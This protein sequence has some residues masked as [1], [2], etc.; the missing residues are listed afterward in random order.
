MTR[1]IDRAHP[2]TTATELVAAVRALD[3]LRWVEASRAELK[4]NH[5]H[6]VV[7]LTNGV[8]FTHYGCDLVES[9]RRTQLQLAAMPPMKE[10]R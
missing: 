1:I 7:T 5:D 10:K 3:A 8:S 4:I 2:V 9:I 6:I